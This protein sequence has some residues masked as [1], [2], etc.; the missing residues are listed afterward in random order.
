V[1]A[2][3]DVFLVPF[4]RPANAGTTSLRAMLLAP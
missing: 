1:A 2:A 4:Q 3:G